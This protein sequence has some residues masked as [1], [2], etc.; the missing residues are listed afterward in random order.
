MTDKQQKFVDEYLIDCNAT[1][2]AIR[3]GYSKNRASE[4]AYQLLQKTTV[5]DAIKAKQAVISDKAQR[6]VADVL[7]D[8]RRITLEAWEK[9]DYRSALRALE[10]EGKHLGMFN[11]KLLVE[12]QKNSSPEAIRLTW[13]DPKDN[14]ES[15]L[16]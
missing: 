6:A 11:D 2:A 8:L 9:G 16:Q 1:Q 3:A 7:A 14:K 12:N 13:L 4:I 5:L 15:G 10:L